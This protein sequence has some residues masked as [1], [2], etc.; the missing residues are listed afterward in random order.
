[1]AEQ[2]ARRGRFE[3]LVLPLMRPLFNAAL[4]LSRDRHTAEDLVQETYLRGY[5]TFD[6]FTE[7]T[8][9]R[10]WLLTILHSVFVNRYHKQRKEP[11]SLPPEEVEVVASRTAA[12][13]PGPP[14][15]KQPTSE[16]VEAALAKLPEHFRAA[17]MLV[18]L[19]DFPYEQAASAL[20]CKL[21][22]LRSR[23]F[24]ARQLLFTELQE[25]ARGLG[26][27]GRPRGGES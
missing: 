4:R 6:N 5:R 7:G 14:G 25:Y 17:V 8:N 15:E 19:H 20:G 24:R 13:D 1:M 27:R 16:E 18:D 3:A 9:A 22:T 12:A 10:A 11:I 21:G 23:L 26:Y 2:Q